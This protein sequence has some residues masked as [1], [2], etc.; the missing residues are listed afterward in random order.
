V[1][2]NYQLY[3]GCLD[4]IL[5]PIL[6]HVSITL[7]LKRYG[8]NTGELVGDDSDRQRAKITKRIFAAHKVFDKKTGGY[9]NGQTVVLLYLVTAKISLPVGFRFYQPD[10]VVVEW[11]KYDNKLTRNHLNAHQNLKQIQLIQTSKN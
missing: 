10:P 4:I 8:I 9:F 6:L 7:V 11:K 2:T 3:H 5:W 1:V